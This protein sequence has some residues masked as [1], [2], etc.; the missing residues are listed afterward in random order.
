MKKSL[1]CQKNSLS[2]K[3]LTR[4]KKGFTLIEL[5]IV[6]AIIG[7]LAA[8]AIPKFGSAQKDAKKNADIASAKTIAN[9]TSMLITQGKIEYPKTDIDFSKSSTEA[10]AIKDQLQSVPEV[11]S[12]SGVTDFTVKIDSDGDVTVFAGTKQEVYPEYKTIK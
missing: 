10:T 11:K 7:I 12:V 9:A 4:K 8:I 1:I 3:S 2:K 6:I 5:I